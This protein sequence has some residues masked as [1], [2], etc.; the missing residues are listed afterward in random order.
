MLTLSVMLLAAQAAAV[1]VGDSATTPVPSHAPVQRPAESER[2]VP[3]PVVPTLPPE[4][5]AGDIVVTG[6]GRQGDPL[7]AV[8]ERSFAAVQAA[9]DAVV[10]PAARAYKRAVPTPFRTGLRNFL[11]NFREPV[12]FANYLLQLKPGKAAETAGRFAINSTIGLVGVI[13]V[14]KRKPFRLPRRRN[15]FANTL[16][17]YGV[18]PG[19]FFFLPLIGSTTLRDLFGNVVDQVAVPIGPIRPLRGSSYT[20][21]IGVLSALDYRIEFDEDLEKA[22]ASDDPYA[23]VRAFYLTRRQAEI[24][25]LRGRGAPRRVA[26]PRVVPTTP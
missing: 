16:G 24:D 8:N 6:R 20:I 17:Y 4:Q 22:R 12:V 7:A 2:V 9:D 11:A 21:P 5:S 19:P 18:G 25:A 23:A 15:S 26:P 14:A 10:A 3:P 1:P 13:D